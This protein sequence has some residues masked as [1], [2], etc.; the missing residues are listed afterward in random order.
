MELLNPAS[1]MRHTLGPKPE[2]SGLKGVPLST[3]RWVNLIDAFIWFYRAMQ[4]PGLY[5]NV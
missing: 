3:G 4:T 5:G 1:L 2:T